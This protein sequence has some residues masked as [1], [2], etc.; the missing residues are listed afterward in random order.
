MLV[1]DGHGG[2]RTVDGRWTVAPISNMGSGTTGWAGGRGW[3]N[4][5]RC[6]VLTDTTGRVAFRASGSAK[7]E[8]IVDRLHRSQGNHRPLQ[9]IREARVSTRNQ[10]EG[11]GMA[12]F[13]D[14][15]VRRAT[16]NTKTAMRRSAVSR[17]CPQCKRKSALRFISDEYGFGHACRWCPYEH[18]KA[19]GSR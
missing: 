4:G 3:S 11:N 7:H 14:G 18:I 9:R 2:Y 12:T 15:G 19:R 16:S 8:R 6:W 13:Q 5:R 17:Q 10:N 1:R